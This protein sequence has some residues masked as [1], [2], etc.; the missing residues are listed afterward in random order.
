MMSAKDSIAV[1]LILFIAARLVSADPVISEFMASNAGAFPDGDGNA[2]DWIEVYNPTPADIELAGWKLRDGTNTWAFPPA[3]T[4]PGGAYLIVFASGQASSEYIDAGGFLHTNFKLAAEGEPLA[5]L[6][7]DNSVAFEYADVP[8]QNENISYGL[9]TGTEQL[10]TPVSPARHLIPAA[11]VA[12]AWRDA[13]FDDAGWA[14]GKAAIGYK[15]EPGPVLGGGAGVHTAYSVLPDTPGNQ[16]YSGSLGMDFIATEEVRVTDL[17]VF[18]DGS[19]GLSTNLIAQLWQRDDKGTPGNF[20]DDLG[21][22]VLATLTFTPA[23][24]GA[25]EGGSRIKPLAAPLVLAP[26]AYSMVAYGFGAS[27][28][29]VNQ[30][31][32]ASESLGID[33]AGGT[34]QFVGTSRFGTAGQFPATADGGPTNRYGAG[35]FKFSPGSASDIGTDLEATMS[36]K[37]AGVLLRVPFDIATP[38]GLDALQFDIGFDD[39]F[40]AWINGVEIARRNSPAPLAHTSKATAAGNATLSLPA[41]LPA[42]TLM[43]SGNVLAIH[44]LNLSE[45]DNDFIISPSLLR[46][47][48]DTLA[49]RFFTTPTPGAPNNPSGIIGFLADTRFSIDRGFFNAPFDVAITS[50][51][52]GAQIRYTIDGSVPTPTNGFDYTGPI[53]IS[54]TTVLRAAAFKDGF[55][56][57]NIDTQ[58]YLFLDNVARRDNSPPGY[59]SS[60]GGVSADYEMDQH[61]PDFARAAGD[62][63]FSP[64]Q[65][66]AAIADSLKSIPTL[67]IVTDIDNLFDPGTG[68]Y[69]NPS[70]RGASWERPVSVEMIGGDGTG[71]FQ[72]D[73]GLR[74]MG[75]TS[76]NLGT[77][78]KLNMRLLFKSQYGASRLDYPLL[79]PEGPDRFNTIAL[80]GNIRDAWVTEIFGFGSA[81]Y[82]GDEWAKRAQSDM[83]QPA[84]RG[85]F[86]HVYL[87]GIYWGL[88]N[89]TE[90]P[91]DDFAETHLG[92]DRSEYDVVKFCCPDR[93]TAGTIAMWDALLDESRAGLGDAAS[94]Q[95]VQGNHPDGTPNPAFPVLIDVDNFID[96]LIN[97]QYHAQGDWPGNYYVIRDQIEGRSEGFKYFTWDNDHAFNGGNPNAGNKVQPSPGN[98]WWTESPGE[99]DIALRANAEYRLRFAD[100]VYKHYFHGG[101]MTVANNIARWEELATTVRPALFA[102]SARWGDSRGS[103]LRTVQDHW[104]VRNVGM[105]DHY[106]PNRQAV[107]FGQMRTH[108]LYPDRDPPEFNQHGGVVAPGFGLRF[109]AETTVYYTTDGSDPRLPGGAINP[110][111]ITASAGTS[112]TT[113]VDTGAAVRAWVPGDERHGTAWRERIFDDSTWTVGTTGVGYEAGSGYADEISLDLLGTMRDINQSAYMRIPFGGVNAADFQSLTLKIKYDDGFV[114]FLNGV[115]IA[116]RNPPVTLSW[117]AGA[118]TSHN[119]QQALDFEEIDVGRHIGTLDPASNV[120][121]I[122]G[123]NFGINSSDFLIVPELVGVSLDAGDTVSLNA[124]TQI[125]ARSFDGSEWSA[126]N[127]ATFITG[128]PPDMENFAVSE[129]MYHPDPVGTAE[130]IEFMNTSATETLDLTGVAFTDGVEFAF[131][132]AFALAPL[133]KAL[134]VRDL[135]AFVAVHGVGLN[136]AGVFANGSALSNGGERIALAGADGSEFLAFTYDDQLPWPQGPDGAGP[137]LVLIAP[138]T[139]PEPGMP[140]NWRPSTL[141]GGNPGGS[142]AVAFGGNDPDADIDADGLSAFLE[143]ALGTS[144]LS[145]DAGLPAVSF[146]A[147]GSLILSFP[148]SLAADDVI[149]EIQSSADLLTWTGSGSTTLLF[150]SLDGAGRRLESWS[151]APTDEPRKFIRLLVRSR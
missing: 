1:I 75:F 149:L 148:R 130:F 11:A 127:E 2:S 109:D 114:A 147:D 134:V 117:E 45:S 65:A 51:T 91:D 136:I 54:T 90:R 122:H 119:D 99:M 38:A 102:E 104:D 150:A 81:T 13:G 40:V 32:A 111:A 15:L 105:V 144:D 41:S 10:V 62:S 43:P 132:T 12:D 68:I 118:S 84:V 30:G 3:T 112:L 137:S 44:G 31:S 107:V 92:G 94:Y 98:N 80:R 129:I 56:P 52:A 131:P 26:G 126:L 24:P 135:A 25:L 21:T 59:P 64:S 50:E 101:A 93:T 145:T 61:P 42:G 22:S 120:L 115:Q 77:T 106:F 49:A 79:G 57:T 88:Y 35:T 100:R 141:T 70:G 133:G 86:M 96:Y 5:L 74:I 33:S 66:S 103:A 83:G 124:T 20:S 128:M 89:P 47:K 69:L 121:A 19:D 125:R 17:G 139:N 87:N 116:A 23:S 48:T 82:I 8:A 67:S 39:G 6:R 60:W 29:N 16:A 143:H 110:K 37:S 76:R 34:I 146:A 123:L 138:E 140:T 14:A 27:D 9:L 58:S 78:P 4:L 72:I 71:Q 108:G 46:I 55:E 95:R 73:A 63:G 36:G 7:P 53:T 142:D 113:L 97:G 28:Q 151:I 85:T 18:D